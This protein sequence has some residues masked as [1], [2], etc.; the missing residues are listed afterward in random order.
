MIRLARAAAVLAAAATLPLTA[1]AVAHADSVA[2]SDPAD[3]T[4]SPADIR[5]VR[6]N[7]A[8]RTVYVR[9]KVADLPAAL[10]NGPGMI[11]WFDTDRSEPGPEF[12]MGVPIFEGGDWAVVRTDGWRP[13]GE[14]LNCPSEVRYLPAQDALRV[15][16]ARRCLDRPRKVRVS[17]KMEDWFDPSHVVRDWAPGRRAFTPWVASD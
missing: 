3:A 17:A 10:E 5:K 7:H 12:R 6:V 16:V 8:E 11:L 2:V 14:Q 1:G 9:V 15:E 4:A 13:V